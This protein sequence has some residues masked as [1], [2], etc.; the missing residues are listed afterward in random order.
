MAA[1]LDMSPCSVIEVDRY[2]EDAVA[3]TMVAIRTSE[4]S[5]CF[6]ETTRCCIPEGY[7]LHA[8]RRKKL[9]SQNSYRNLLLSIFV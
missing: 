2:S 6:Y 5:V 1:F 8:L 9:K 7:H 4:T 3:L